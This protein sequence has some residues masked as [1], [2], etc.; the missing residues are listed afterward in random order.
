MFFGNEDEL[1]VRTVTTAASRLVDELKAEATLRETS[2]FHQAAIFNS[3]RSF[4]R[5]TLPSYLA[6]DPGM[7]GWIREAAKA[8]PIEADTPLSYATASVPPG[9]A[10]AVWARRQA[11]SS[12]LQRPERPAPAGR[13]GAENLELL[14]QAWL[15][16]TELVQD[17]LEAEG[18]VLWLYYS[19]VNG[20]ADKLPEHYVDIAKHIGGLDAGRRLKFCSVLIRGL[21]APAPAS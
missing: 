16:Y 1:A 15:A 19:A 7:M 3:V 21:N 18:L 2:D 8:L 10:A 20:T 6:H 17:E 13:A 9:V 11:A 5:G 12:F 14:M 4:R